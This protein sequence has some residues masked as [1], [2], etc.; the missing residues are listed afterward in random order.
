MGLTT[1]NSAA[2]V[3]ASTLM[4]LIGSTDSLHPYRVSS[5][6]CIG[7]SLKVSFLMVPRDARPPA[8]PHVALPLIRRG[9]VG[10]LQLLNIGGSQYRRIERDGHLVDGASEFERHLVVVIIHRRCAGAAGVEGL[11]KRLDQGKG[12][13]QCLGR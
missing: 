2:N 1:G 12:M 8:I 3:T 13:L 11:V 5:V 9:A 4:K 10:T 7:P 6:S